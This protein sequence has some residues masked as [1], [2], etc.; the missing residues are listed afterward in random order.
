MQE[1]LPYTMLQI[2]RPLQHVISLWDTGMLKNKCKIQTSCDATASRMTVGSLQSPWY[3]VRWFP[4]I[5]QSKH[6]G[7]CSIKFDHGFEASASKHPVVLV[8]WIYGRAIGKHH[9]GSCWPL[10]KV[11]TLGS[12][13][14]EFVASGSIFPQW[15]T[16]VSICGDTS[17]CN[18]W[19]S[20][21]TNKT[22]LVP[23]K[24]LTRVSIPASLASWTSLLIDNEW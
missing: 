14:W 1:L 2:W 13:I 22:P 10:L 12:L 11:L 19:L 23:P 6:L 3:C 15:E 18:S 17:A 8:P 5:L 20:C 24:I 4:Q 9:Q 16:M 7:H 21:N